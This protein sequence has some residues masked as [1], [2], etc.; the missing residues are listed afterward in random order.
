M[1]HYLGPS[2]VLRL[3]SGCLVFFKIL[4]ETIN[5]SSTDFSHPNWKSK[6]AVT[7]F[8]LRRWWTWGP[9]W[10]NQKQQTCANF[11]L[12]TRKIL[13]ESQV[14]ELRTLFSSQPGRWESADGRARLVQ[15]EL[16]WEERWQTTGSRVPGVCW[17]SNHCRATPPFLSLPLIEPNLDI[18]RVYSM[19]PL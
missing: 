11:V 7:H 12:T 6:A 2:R 16:T 14:G 9:G 17:L 10:A 13:C 3:D 19:G 18:W 8:S 4:N 5:I 1:R 15:R